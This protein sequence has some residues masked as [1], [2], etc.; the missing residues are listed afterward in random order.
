[1]PTIYM[2]MH[3]KTIFISFLLLL[4][5]ACAG[6]QHGLDLLDK[7]MFAY[8]RALRWQN[9]DVVIAMHR[10]AQQKLTPAQREHMKKYRVTGYEQVYNQVGSDGKTAT[11]VVE[12][13]YYRE[14]DMTIRKMT[15]NNKW[16]YDEPTSRW[17]LLNPI[18]DFK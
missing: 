16:E 4:A 11:Q 1:M 17:H 5:S 8:E 13:N 7:S 14:A 15:L 9:Y 10:N 12:I 18:P 2:N 3:Y 6:N